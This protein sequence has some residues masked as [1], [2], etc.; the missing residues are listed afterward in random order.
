MTN[1]LAYFPLWPR[2]FKTIKLAI[3]DLKPYVKVSKS[4]SNKLPYWSGQYCK[5]FTTIIN[6]CND[7]GQYYKTTIM[8]VSYG[9]N[10]A[11]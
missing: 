3:K 4:V 6:Y 1:T 7:S 9:P 8:I 10:L 5:T 11:I 2:K